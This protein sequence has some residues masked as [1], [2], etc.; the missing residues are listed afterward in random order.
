MD[1]VEL[2]AEAPFVL[3]VIDLEPTVGRKADRTL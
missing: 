3:G 1:E 2:L